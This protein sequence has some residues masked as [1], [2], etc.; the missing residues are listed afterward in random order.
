MRPTV[1]QLQR[2]EVLVLGCSR[3]SSSKKSSTS[4][5][6]TVTLRMFLEDP[7]PKMGNRAPVHRKI[8]KFCIYFQGVYS[9]NSARL[10]N[11]ALHA[12]HP[13]QHA[14]GSVHMK[15]NQFDQVAWHS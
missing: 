8:Q 9:N 14:P 4:A 6:C 10:P 15:Q 3:A 7:A 12:T 5:H 11:H 13:Q 2:R 1:T